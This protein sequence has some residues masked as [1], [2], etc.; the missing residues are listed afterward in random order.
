MPSDKVFYR[1]KPTLIVSE[2]FYRDPEAVRKL[3]LE[4]EF[5]PGIHTKQSV[6]KFLF[7]GLKEQF[8]RLL[9]LPIKNWDLYP[10]NGSFQLSSKED[11]IWRHSAAYGYM[12]AICLSEQP[13][14]SL[15]FW[16]EQSGCKEKQQQITSEEYLRDDSKWSLV[17]SISLTKN[18]LIIWDAQLFHR[19]ET[20]TEGKVIHLFMFDA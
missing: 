15:T 2:N 8:E 6:K 19:L 3:A 14:C 4:Q 9:G 20:P 17:D 1:Q 5:L 10:H 16:K 12:A 7:A 13:D 11:Q 18:R